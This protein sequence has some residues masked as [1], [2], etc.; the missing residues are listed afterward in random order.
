MAKHHIPFQLLALPQ[1]P[2]RQISEEE[3][4]EQMPGTNLQ[5]EESYHLIVEARIKGKP[6]NLILDTGASKTVLDKEKYQAILCPYDNSDP[7][8]SSGISE[9]IEVQFV[10]LEGLS[11]NGIEIDPFISGLTRLDHINEIYGMYNLPYIDGLIGN[12]ILIKYQALINYSSNLLIIE[13][14]I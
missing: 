10:W 6:V 7:I 4:E 8:F 5:T 2:T 13:C 14:N 12:D 11:F 3:A 9:N 1:M